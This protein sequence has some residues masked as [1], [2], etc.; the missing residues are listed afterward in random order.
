MCNPY[1]SIYLHF[2]YMYVCVGLHGFK[3]GIKIMI[4]NNWTQKVLQMS[5]EL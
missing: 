2:V 4:N 5:L 3:T 1:N